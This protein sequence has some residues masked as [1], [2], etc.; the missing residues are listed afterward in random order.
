[1]TVFDCYIL[2]QYWISILLKSYPNNYLNISNY[3]H[4]MY[5]T[6]FFT[7]ILPKYSE[8]FTNMFYF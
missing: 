3:I 7:K 4:N 2:G 6:S 1:M 8:Y 5:L